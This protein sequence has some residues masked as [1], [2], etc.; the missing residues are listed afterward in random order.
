MRAICIDIGN[1]AVKFGCFVENALVEVITTRK[2]R[3]A[4]VLRRILKFKATH[5][6]YSNVGESNNFFVQ[7]L[8]DEMDLMLLTDRTKLPIRVSYKS[9]TLGTDRIALAAA[10][11][12][13]FKN[14]NILIIAAGTCI[15]YNFV[16][17]QGV[18][19]GGA[20]SP[21]LHMRL[22]AMHS[23]TARLPQIRKIDD[24]AL[25]GDSTKASML[26]GVVNG[27]AYEMDGFIDACKRE[28]KSFDAVLTGG[29]ARY[30]EPRLKSKIFAQPH[31]ALYGL[32][33]ILQHNTGAI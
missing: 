28:Y 12:A 15:T 32:H 8:K 10:A 5:G 21:G 20:I 14:R 1:T 26:S 16:S 13:A 24:A 17:Y 22:N 30:F 2:L 25:V 11:H 19:G 3:D 27:A 33:A 23:F 6:I 4:T 29:D 7:S 18:F 9:N 31:A